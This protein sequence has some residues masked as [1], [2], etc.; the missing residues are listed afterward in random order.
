MFKSLSVEKRQITV[1]LEEPL[2]IPVERLSPALAVSLLGRYAI[3]TE[4][5]VRTGTEETRISREEAEGLARAHGGLEELLREEQWQPWLARFVR[6]AQE[7]DQ[8]ITE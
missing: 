8:Q 7:A 6:Q 4:V 2:L 3:F 5:V 1:E